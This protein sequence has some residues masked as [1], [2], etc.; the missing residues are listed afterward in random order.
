MTSV[1]PSSTI[2]PRL[3][4]SLLS[5][6]NQNFVNRWHFEPI[7]FAIDEIRFTPIFLFRLWS[8]SP[9]PYILEIHSQAN[10]AEKE[11]EKKQLL[12]INVL[13]LHNYPYEFLPILS[14]DRG[15]LFVSEANKTKK[16]RKSPLI[17]LIP[18]HRFNFCA[19]AAE[20]V[21]RDDTNARIS[22]VPDGHFCKRSH[23]I[24]KKSYSAVWPPFTESAMQ[25]RAIDYEPEIFEHR[26]L[27]FTRGIYHLYK[28][29]SSTP[30]Y[31]RARANR[32]VPRQMIIASNII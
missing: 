10:F 7:N 8:N 11:R 2:V 16:R 17:R 23:V 25:L 5:L 22:F 3:F 27:L 15:N 18:H 1:I 24:A 14:S 31:L 30:R 6:E 19:H 4:Q 32:V 26:T 20:H 9:F 28:R 13:F 29:E 12:A 21:K